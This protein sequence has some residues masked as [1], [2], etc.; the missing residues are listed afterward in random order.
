[1]VARW[2]L[3]HAVM[4]QQEVFLS[5]FSGHERRG[6]PVI[7][8]MYAGGQLIYAHLKIMQWVIEQLSLSKA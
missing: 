3:G 4:Q 6:V 5:C 1:M 7:Q 8:T 2:I